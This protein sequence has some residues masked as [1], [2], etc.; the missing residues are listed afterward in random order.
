VPWS[1]DG[2]EESKG[3]FGGSDCGWGVESQWRTK[4]PDQF[5]GLCGKNV[6]GGR[7]GTTKAYSPLKSERMYC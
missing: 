5:S 3:G 7:K 2:Y 4:I 1:L 6:A